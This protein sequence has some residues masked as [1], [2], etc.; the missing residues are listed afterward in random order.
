VKSQLKLVGAGLGVAALV[1]LL[2]EALGP[3]P[4]ADFAVG[5]RL[6]GGALLAPLALIFVGGL[7]T[8]LTPCVYPLIPITV[9]IFGANKAQ[10]RGRA[11][12]LTLAYNL[13][14]AA[15]FT[16][17]GMGAAMTGKAFGRLLGDPYVVSGLAA[18]F[19]VFAASMFGAFD[20]QLPSS[21]QQKLGGLGKAGYAGAFLMGLVA[22]LVAAPCTGPVLSGVLLHVAATQDIAVGALLLFTYALGLGL[23]FFLIGALSL[24][25]PKSG[26]WMEA[27][28]SVFGIA[29]AALALTYLRDAFP[30][31]RQAMSLRAVAYGALVAAA[32]AFAGIVFG[33]VHRSFHSRPAEGLLKGL[34]VALVVLGI[35]LRP[36][37]PM[38]SPSAS[39]LAWLADEG[40]AVAQ[41]ASLKRPVLID[42]SAEWCAACKELDKYVFSDDRFER[43]ASRFVLVRVDGTRDSPE[44]QR[45]YA[46]YRVAGL[47]TV[48]FV[49][50]AGKMLDELTV[51]GFLRPQDFVSLMQRVR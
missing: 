31:L 14:I 5:E 36:E 51:T 46:R 15:M 38:A 2:P 9:S 18:L 20:F 19:L 44:L 13:G 26:P 39:K 4:R 10:S 42:F 23:P 27:V 50:A 16:S 41:A 35:A 37:A 6:K 30:S 1:L 11:V 34:G 47:P 48:V 8:A 43:E 24:R 17:L 25:L 12:A 33:A 28:K 7:L 32:L 49:D 29:L 22:G 21:V 45:L 3:G 40:Q